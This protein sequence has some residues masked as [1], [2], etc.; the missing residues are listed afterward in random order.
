MRHE[1]KSCL[2]TFNFI[3]KIFNISKV[4]RMTIK[5]ISFHTRRSL[6][7]RNLI[8]IILFMTHLSGNIAWAQQHSYDPNTDNDNGEQFGDCL[9][10][11]KKYCIEWEPLLFELENCL[12]QHITYLSSS[13]RKHMDNTDFRKYHRNKTLIPNF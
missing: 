7:S 10:D 13:C 1:R 8:L 2:F 3:F 5:T 12:Q 4:S 9:R 11:I 6:N